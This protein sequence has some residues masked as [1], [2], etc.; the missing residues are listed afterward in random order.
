METTKKLTAQNQW[1]LIDREQVLQMTLGDVEFLAEMIDLF[2]SYLPQQMNDIKQAI[3][4]RN[5]KALSFAAHACKGTIVNYTKLAPFQLLLS[6]EE[7]AKTGQLEKS[8]I[9]YQSL[10]NEISQLVAELK[11]LRRQECPDFSSSPT[12]ITYNERQ[13]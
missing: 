7:D 1:R 13:F 4:K 9:T 10:E 3:E 8:H 11:T 6:L 12:D 2:L 5:P